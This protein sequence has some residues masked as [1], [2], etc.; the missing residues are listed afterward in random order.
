MI[1]HKIILG[2]E[3]PKSGALTP[4]T[5]PSGTSSSYTQKFLTNP[6]C[7]G[8]AATLLHFTSRWSKPLA[9]RKC[10]HDQ[11]DSTLPRDSPTASDTLGSFQD[12]GSTTVGTST[13]RPSAK[14]WQTQKCTFLQA[15]GKGDAVWENLRDEASSKSLQKGF[16]TLVLV[17]APGFHQTFSSFSLKHAFR[18]TRCDSS[19]KIWFIQWQ[20]L[21][22]LWQASFEYLQN[23]S[24]SKL[25]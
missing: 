21:K 19:Y 3:W 9:T 11:S 18:L 22:S 4:E 14:Q 20:G 12:Q 23:T 5:E 7:P 2:P 8:S 25:Q 10:A 15:F 1:H 6:S 16:Y 17:S 24:L 13:R